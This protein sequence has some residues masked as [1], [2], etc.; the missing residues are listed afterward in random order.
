MEEAS[1]D[2]RKLSMIE[3]AN[4]ISN[5]MTEIKTERKALSGSV[6]HGLTKMRSFFRVEEDLD[7]PNQEENTS[8]DALRLKYK[9]IMS[10]SRYG[11]LYNDVLL[12]L[13]VFSTIE[14]IATTY[15]EG[16][17]GKRE[18]LDTQYLY[19]VDFFFASVFGIDW[20]IYF[21]L[22]DS[23]S[24]YFSRFELLLYYSLYYNAL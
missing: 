16:Y 24:D 10:R 12:V 6:P 23:K 22:A 17:Q 15:L 19:I 5:R 3:I 7:I 2:K 20:L 4:S 8:F 18:Q 9:N 21:L 13:T 11:M 1:Y 14:F